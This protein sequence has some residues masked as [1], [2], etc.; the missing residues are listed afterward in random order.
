MTASLY[1]LFRCVC[2]RFFMR[3]TGAPK[4]TH[5]RCLRCRPPR[6]RG[7]MLETRP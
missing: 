4:G 1:V 6:R 7:V 5:Y 2:G 3:H